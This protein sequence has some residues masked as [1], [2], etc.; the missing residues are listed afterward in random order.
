MP[1]TSRLI[2]PK[3]LITATVICD[4]VPGGDAAV[5]AEVD[6]LGPYRLRWV[7]SDGPA[8][9]RQGVCCASSGLESGAR[10]KSWGLKQF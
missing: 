9:A 6:V 8:A 5:K 2:P 4:N 7:L 1:L 10:W 3:L